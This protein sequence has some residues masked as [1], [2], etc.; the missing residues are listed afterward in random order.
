M[1]QPLALLSVTD[2]TGVVE[3]ARGLAELGFELLSTGGTARAIR[4][5]GLPVLEVADLTGFPE[6]LDGRVKTLHPKVHGGLL[7]DLRLER[8][9]LQ[10][11]EAGIRPISVVAVNLYRFE[12]TVT[13]PHS[14]EEAVESI[15]IGGPAMIRAAAKNHAN[16]AVVVDPADYPA[17]LEAL[18]GNRLEGMRRS[19]AAKAFRHTAFSDSLVS[20]YLSGGARGAPLAPPSVR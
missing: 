18:R 17:V 4:D 3:F 5:A 9:R 13:G 2:K 8:H 14:P 10:L 1:N 15:D 12:E 19:L 20:R 16:V 7:A 6:M 11:E